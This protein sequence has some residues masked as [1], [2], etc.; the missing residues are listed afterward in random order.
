MPIYKL[1]DDAPLIPANTFASAEATVIGK[2]RL[3]ERAS[4]WPGAAIR[5]DNEPITIGDGS[6][7]QEGAVLHA[8][9]GF[10][11]QVGANVTIGHQAMLHHRRGLADRHPGAGHG[12]FYRTRLERIS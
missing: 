1:G 5:G 6:K 3:A 4:V 2:V 9:P 11:L 7:V 10:P 8:D 12:E